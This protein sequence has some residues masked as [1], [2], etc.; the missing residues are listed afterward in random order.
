MKEETPELDSPES[1]VDWEALA[2]YLAGESTD[3][4]A[5]AMRRWLAARP[6]R[7]ELVGA[8]D[9]A[10]P[11]FAPPPDVDVE[12]A[13][14]RVHERMDETA[15]LPLRSRT[16]ISPA[17]GGHAIAPV[18]KRTWLRAAAIVAIAIGAPLVWRAI[19]D[20]GADTPASERVLR[21]AIGQ[22][23]SV[24]LPDS[25]RVLIGPGSELRVAAGFGA[26]GR[27]RS[28]EL[29]GEAYFDVV[30]DESRPFVVRAGQAVIRDV[31]TTFVVHSD[32]HEGVRVVV[33][34]GVVRLSIAGAA[35]D[36]GVLLRP[37]DRAMLEV[38]GRVTVDRS[39]A[40]DADLAFT[41]GQLVFRDAPMAQ[42]AADLRRW[43]GITLRFADSS[44]A[45]KHLNDDF[46]GKDTP[47]DILKTLTL[48]FEAKG[49][50]RGDTIVLRDAR[51]GSASTR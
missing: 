39:S 47:A 12:A 26:R 32:D 2:R 37:K 3:E 31:G 41:R 17:F 20:S 50:L 13:L 21:T 45:G 33:T 23:D 16:P 6:D 9:R 11:R 15:V 8:L 44:L 27:E 4:E 19:R 36:S 1:P 14:R 43:Y 42:V 5:A 35:G 49:E 40:S 22:R 30:H 38:A 7:E 29:R 51:A 10:L 25:S 48:L 24:V 34:S 18:W 28:V 46:T